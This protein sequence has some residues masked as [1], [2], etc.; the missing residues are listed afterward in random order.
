V[1]KNFRHKGLKRLYEQGS[2]RGLPAAYADK[3]NRILARLEAATEPEHMNLPG[4]RLHP[5]EGDLKGFWSVTVSGNWR[6]IWRFEGRDVADV[7][8]LDYH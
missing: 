2:K 7:D 3:L 8:F 5:L 1:I 4:W 6:V